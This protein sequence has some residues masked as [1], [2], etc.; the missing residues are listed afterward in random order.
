[1]IVIHFQE[2]AL[3][4]FNACVGE[5]MG[6]YQFSDTEKWSFTADFAMWRFYT[7]ELVYIRYL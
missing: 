4:V 7:G 6:G 3:H 1:V 2:I 5:N